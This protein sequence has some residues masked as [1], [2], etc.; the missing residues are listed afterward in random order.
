MTATHRLALPFIL[1]GQA[2]KELFHNEALQALD[3]IVAAAVEEPPRSAPPATPAI[4]SCYI[5]S[6][7]PSGAWVGHADSLAG[8]TPAG[9]RYVTPVEGL[10][11]LIRSNGLIASYR[12]GGWSVGIL[13][14]ER[15]EIGGQQVVGPRGGAILAPTTGA[16]IDTEARTAVSAILAALRLHGLIAP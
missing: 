12:A 16:V 3:L 11:A 8:M 9:W 6:T 1:P 15:V 14:G 7:T 13:R 2:Q 4:G 5:V 10:A